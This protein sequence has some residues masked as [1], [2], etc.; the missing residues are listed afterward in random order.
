MNIL[1]ELGEIAAAKYGL[2]MKD[3]IFRA[4]DKLIQDS[5]FELVKSAIEDDYADFDENMKQYFDNEKTGPV[6]K[7][8]LN[9]MGIINGRKGYYSKVENPEPEQNICYWINMLIEELSHIASG[10]PTITMATNGD[11]IVNGQ[12]FRAA[13]YYILDILGSSNPVSAETV[14]YKANTSCY[15]YGRELS[16]IKVYGNATGVGEQLTPGGY[17]YV[18]FKL[19]DMLSV[20]WETNYQLISNP[21]GYEKLYEGDSYTVRV[22]DN[23]LTPQPSS[24][25]YGPLGIYKLELQTFTTEIEP[26]F[27]LTREPI[28]ESQ[29]S[30]YVFTSNES[31]STSISYLNN[32]KR[33]LMPTTLGGQPLTTVGNTTFGYSDVNTVIIPEGVTTIE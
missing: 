21:V 27:K 28:Y 9:L 7:L 29:D 6:M 1:P 31:S 2:Q 23:I 15:I 14:S 17:Y 20:D 22:P 24:I 10:M 11:G 8:F 12:R 18:V 13:M 4:F 3:P 30:D 16:S 5:K 25:V 33:L 32:K 19:Y 26:T